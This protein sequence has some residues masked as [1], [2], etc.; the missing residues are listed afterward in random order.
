[1]KQLALSLHNYH[2]TNFSFPPGWMGGN[3]AGWGMLLLPYCEFKPIYGLVNFNAVM[4]N[5]ISQTA[6]NRNVDQIALV[7][8]LFKC[9]SSGDSA[10]VTTTRCNGTGKGSGDYQNRLFQA[11][12]ANYL[13]N[14][15]TLIVDGAGPNVPPLGSTGTATVGSGVPGNITG[16]S[17]AGV[18]DNGGV[19]FE[20]SRIKISDISDGTTNTALIAEHYGATCL[21][22]ISLSSQCTNTDSCFAFWANADGYTGSTGI[23]VASDVCFSSLCGVNGNAAVPA[24]AAL[25]AV[26]PA[27]G[28]GGPGDISSQHEAGAQ[29][30]LADGSVR[31]FSTSTDNTLLQ[32][33]CNRGDQQVISLPAN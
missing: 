12:T 10:A 25:A 18:V 24:N 11:A 28:V 15:G 14:A 8:N 17:T 7:L 29:I 19:M 26:H 32:N 27:A 9:P 16:T 3:Q 30:A 2:D 20:D 33:V 6:P 1:M 31:Y 4:V 5:T 23:T 22:G 13:A 21:T